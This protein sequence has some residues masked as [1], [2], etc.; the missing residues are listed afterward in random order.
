GRAGAVAPAGVLEMQPMPQDDVEERPRLAVVLK[1]RLVRIELDDALGIPVLEDYAEL[2][3]ASLASMRQLSGSGKSAASG[4]D[5]NLRYPLDEG[6]W[7]GWSCITEQL[8]TDG[9]WIEIQ[10]LA[11]VAERVRPAPVLRG[12]PGIGVH[13][14]PLLSPAAGKTIFAQVQNG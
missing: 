8:R 3:H 13:V 7:A 2:G 14:Q 10:S 1:R 5:R 9:G 6:G 11:Q 12:N 4:C